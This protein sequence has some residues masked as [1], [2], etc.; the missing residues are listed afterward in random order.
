MILSLPDELISLIAGLCSLSGQ[1][2][3]SRCCRHLHHISNHIL[4]QNDVKNHES[5]SVFHAIAWCTNQDVALRTLSAAHRSGAKFNI[6]RDARNFHPGNLQAKEQFQCSPIHLAA[7]RGL[8]NII[9]FLIQHGVSPDGP[10]NT[11]KPPLA[12]A[13]FFKNESTA[14][15]LLRSGASIRQHLLQFDAVSDAVRHGLSNLLG[16]MIEMFQLDVDADL[17][18]GCSMLMVAI[19]H[20][21]KSTPTLHQLSRNHQFIALSWTLGVGCDWLAQNLD[22]GDIFDLI[23]YILSQRPW[24]AQRNQKVEVLGRLLDILRRLKYAS[25]PDSALSIEELNC[26]LDALLERALSLEMADAGLASLL[27]RHGARI[28]AG[29]FFKL[30]EI[31]TSKTFLEDSVRSLYRYPKLL[32]SFDFVY[33][34]CLSTPPPR[35]SFMMR[36]FLK[37]T[38][39]EAVRLVYNL[40]RHNLPLTAKGVKNVQGLMAQGS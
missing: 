11:R 26:F 40:K 7:R 31:L 22:F 6:C 38:P 18:Y 5:S 28:Q 3:L 29:V 15:V 24:L 13:I 27:L 8:D 23:T 36:Y 35:P 9:T 10:P 39:V 30:L 4:Y 16:L 1:A 2:S 14:I 32:Q 17:G 12:E 34:Y 37:A 21:K 33:T 20:G 25:C 19:N